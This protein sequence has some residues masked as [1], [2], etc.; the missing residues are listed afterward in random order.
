MKLV[1]LVGCPLLAAV[2]A[3]NSIYLLPSLANLGSGSASS[4]SETSAI[5]GSFE[6][7]I[8]SQHLTGLLSHIYSVPAS[9]GELHAPLLNF[10]GIP[11]IIT[12]TECL[13]LPGVAE[14]AGSSFLDRPKGDVL[15]AFHGLEQEPMLSASKVA[16]D[17][18]STD[19]QLAQRRLMEN[20]LEFDR[21][22]TVIELEG[23]K[24]DFLLAHEYALIRKMGE[25][26]AI[27]VKL[28]EFDDA[29]IL[30]RFA[31]SYPS[32]G[33]DRAEDV[34]RQSHFFSS[35]YRVARRYETIGPCQCDPLGTEHALR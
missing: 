20:V 17:V 15:L 21:E 11:I 24:V 13:I 28:P 34:R 8:D 9:S 16:L 22:S 31:L 7:V 30:R 10:Q 2:A 32:S 35:I 19:F 33:L 25:R 1:L 3:A 14:S 12:T 26:G 5:D 27:K 23:S 18:S 6:Q 4:S 29:E